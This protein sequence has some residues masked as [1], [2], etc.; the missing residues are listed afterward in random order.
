MLVHLKKKE[1]WRKRRKTKKRVSEKKRR[2][3]RK[4]E[5]IYKKGESEREWVSQLALHT[6]ALH[7]S[8]KTFHRLALPNLALVRLQSLAITLI[9]CQLC[10]ASLAAPT[11]AKKKSVPL[12]IRGLATPPCLAH[13]HMQRKEM[14][15]APPTPKH[16]A[17]GSCHQ[18][19]WFL[20]TSYVCN[21]ALLFAWVGMV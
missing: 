9:R 1:R 18:G 14:H 20:H 12:M 10:I 8:R 19:L 16:C 15:F 3:K 5:G 2:K 13:A 11:H 4:R 21:L 17:N 6:M 7:F